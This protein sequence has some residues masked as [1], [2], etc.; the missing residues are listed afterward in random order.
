[1]KLT[2]AQRQIYSMISFAGGS[3]ANVCGSM[4]LNGQKD[5]DFLKEKVNMLFALNDGLR[6]QLYET[7]CGI[8]Q[9][10]L[11]YKKRDIPVK[12]FPDYDEFYDFA[13]D[14]AK[15]P[16]PNDCLCEILLVILPD[17]YGIIPKINHLVGD[18]WAIALLGSQFNQLVSGQIPSTF[19]LSEQIAKEKTYLESN[20]FKRDADFFEDKFKRFNNPIYIS[21]VVSKSFEAKRKTI[22][23]SKEIT[24]EIRSF[25]LKNETTVFSLLF[26][27][28]SVCF[29]NIKFNAD[30]FCI[31]TTVL[32]R[33]GEKEKNTIGSFVNY[34]PI[35][36]KLNPNTDILVNLKN[37]EAEF[38]TTLR[39]QKYNYQ[40]ALET[41][42][43]KDLIIQKPFDVIFNYQNSSIMG[44]F[45]ESVWLHN[46]MQIESLQIHIED[47]DN[48]GTFKIHYDYQTEKFAEKDI[49]D[50]HN[51][52][53][54]LL[55]HILDNPKKK[56][57][58]L[59]MLSAD[60]KKKLLY[61]FNDTSHSYDIPENS[62]L[63]SLFE[64]TA[65]ENRNKTCI[66]TAEKNLTFGELLNISENLDIKIRK[67][68]EAKK[69]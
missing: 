21:D 57:S 47:R 25:A 16:L 34:V 61:D 39:H 68:T 60:E 10:I 36:V 53:N 69:S 5:I 30:E 38:L 6:I 29:S 13:C 35:F 41:F 19:S 18:A 49:V 8:C 66:R 26:S 52:F 55:T 54:C 22:V 37:I 45:S 32:N 28:F 24:N 58:E 63:Y 50:F 15:T 46:G 9:R 44:D 4:L 14:Y 64:K 12:Y 11:A 65:E 67:I 27:A 43:S 3:V 2:K 20:R 51:H 62:T 40:V 31:G 48:E 23:L 56:I 42:R 33:S 17:R 7:D 1:M 59:E